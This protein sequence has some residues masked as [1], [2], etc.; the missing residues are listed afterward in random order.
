MDLLN[1]GNF[2]VDVKIMKEV[3]SG[4][5]R[6]GMRCREGGSSMADLGSIREGDFHKL[7]SLC[8]VGSRTRRG[9]LDLG[10]AVWGF[11]GW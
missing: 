11:S 6:G 7:R 2:V 10:F 5:E 9:G 3:E 8:E 1:F 4:N